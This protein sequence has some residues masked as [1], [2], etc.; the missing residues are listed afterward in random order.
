[1]PAIIQRTDI[2][3]AK[4]PDKFENYKTVPLHYRYSRS[5]RGEGGEA[6]LLSKIRAT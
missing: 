2:T 6:T 1:M 4:K 3:K 5:Q